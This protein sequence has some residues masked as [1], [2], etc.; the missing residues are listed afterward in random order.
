MKGLVFGAGF[1]G[2]RIADKFN[3]YL[4]IFPPLLFFGKFRQAY[5]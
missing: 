3:Y 5:F 1:I 4:I 2:K